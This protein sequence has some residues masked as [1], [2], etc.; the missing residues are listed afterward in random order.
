MYNNR[1]HKIAQKSFQ[2][3]FSNSQEYLENVGKNVSELSKGVKI[4][5]QDKLKEIPQLIEDIKSG[6]PSAKPKLEEMAESGIDLVKEFAPYLGGDL[7]AK[8]FFAL[9]GL[10][11]AAGLALGPALLAGGAGLLAAEGAMSLAENLKGDIAI[12]KDYLGDFHKDLDAISKLYPKNKDLQELIKVMRKYGD[13]GLK[14]ILDVKS[15]RKAN[16][17]NY[18]IAI[19]GE[20][21]WGSYAHQGLSGAAMGAAM[22]GGPIGAAIGGLGMALADASKDIFHNWQSNAYKAAAY[23][24]EL[25]QKTQTLVNQIN[26]YDKIFGNQ[27]KNVVD[28]F[29]VYVRKFIYKEKDLDDPK[30]L[31]GYLDILKKYNQ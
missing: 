12:Y 26:K 23:T 18:R 17:K 24:N 3:A 8:E 5:T 1:H 27:L 15:R 2:E 6:K 20:A 22:G 29:D 7:A 10:E 4:I 28:E 19:V 16:R 13:D 30:N 21:N 31:L 25:K 9:F 11:A 14:I